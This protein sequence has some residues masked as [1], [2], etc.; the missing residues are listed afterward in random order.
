MS[1]LFLCKRTYEVSNAHKQSITNT[2][3]KSNYFQRILFLSFF[4][5]SPIPSRTLVMS[6]IRLFCTCKTHCTRICRRLAKER[7]ARNKIPTRRDQPLEFPR[8]CLDQ[9]CHQAHL[10]AS[11]GTSLSRALKRNNEKRKEI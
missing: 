5:I 8:H 9:L 10:L 4:S 3:S 2:G 11:S 1:H 7:H 6:Y